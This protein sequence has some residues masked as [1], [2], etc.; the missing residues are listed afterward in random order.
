[1]IWSGKPVR[2]HLEFID[3]ISDKRHDFWYHNTF[4]YDLRN[5]PDVHIL[6]NWH[7][8]RFYV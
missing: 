4:N 1:M 7:L 8:Q 3:K 5:M 2:H 6:V